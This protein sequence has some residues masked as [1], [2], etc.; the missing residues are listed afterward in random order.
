M[1]DDMRAT[2]KKKAPDRPSYDTST[3]AGQKRLMQE[4]V[5]LEYVSPRRIATA[6]GDYGADPLGPDEGGVFRWRMVPSGDVVDKAE[7]DRR[8]TRGAKQHHATKKSPAQLDREIAEALGRFPYDEPELQAKYRIE[9][10]EL[11]VGQRFDYFGQPFEIVKIGRDKA[12]TIQIA[13]R[14]VTH[15]GKEDFLDHRSFPMRAFYQQHLR[16][17]RG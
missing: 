16:P 10:S 6:P 3:G 14:Y 9:P 13:R 7:H 2:R 5:G 12:R 1:L 8:L 15:S 11:R 17:L 4:S